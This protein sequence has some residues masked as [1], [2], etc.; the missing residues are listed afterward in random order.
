M[1]AVALKPSLLSL[2]FAYR[3]ACTRERETAADRMGDHKRVADY[4]DAVGRHLRA[5]EVRAN[6]EAAL[7]HAISIINEAE[8]LANMETTL[9]AIENRG[10]HHPWCAIHRLRRPASPCVCGVKP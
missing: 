1:T 4:A 8:L 2:F 10:E 7:E 9:Q 3:D 6:T 5:V